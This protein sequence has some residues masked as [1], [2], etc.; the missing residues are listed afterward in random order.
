MNWI[1]SVFETTDILTPATLETTPGL[2]SWPIGVQPH[3]N[4]ST[5]AVFD[6]LDALETGVQTIPC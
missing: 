6:G 5:G 3:L 4:H 2:F 1:A